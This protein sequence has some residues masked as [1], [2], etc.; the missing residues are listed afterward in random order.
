MTDSDTPNIN[1][2]YSIVQ[3]EIENDTVQELEPD[4]YKNIS[5]YVGKLKRSEYD[6]IEAKIKDALINMTS[7]LTEI[8][9][10]NRLEKSISSEPVNHSNL[11]DEEKFILDC[12]EEKRERAEA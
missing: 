8:L 2:L 10:R 6:N 1:S 3:R 5:D 9:L 12:E 4:F 11:L 7:E